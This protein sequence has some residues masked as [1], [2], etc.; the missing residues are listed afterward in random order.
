M[1]GPIAR[2]RAH[3]KARASWKAFD[4]MIAD[5]ALNEAFLKYLDSCEED[6]GRPG[7]VGDLVPWLKAQPATFESVALL[8]ALGES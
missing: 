8:S 4:R 5:P 1:T 3:R 6:L 2:Y 7:T